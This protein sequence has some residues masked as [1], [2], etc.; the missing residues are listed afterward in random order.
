MNLITYGK[1]INGRLVSPG[2]AI[3]FPAKNYLKPVNLTPPSISGTPNV[4]QNLSRV[5]GTWQNQLIITAEWQVNGIRRG[6]AFSSLLVLPGDLG[7]TI[8]VLERATNA[9][10]GAS[11]RSAGVVIV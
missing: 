8:T 5:P 2:D 10:G 9:S 1:S 6:D 4:G 3:S 7:K 11:S